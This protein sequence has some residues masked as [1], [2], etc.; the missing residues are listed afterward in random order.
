MGDNECPSVGCDHE[1]AASTAHF[2]EAA[3]FPQRMG[4]RINLFSIPKYEG[5]ILERQDL[6]ESRVENCCFT[7]AHVIHYSNCIISL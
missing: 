7:L 5:F 1:D 6:S 3:D 2:W 4:V